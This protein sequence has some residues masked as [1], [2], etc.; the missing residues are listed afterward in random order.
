MRLLVLNGSPRPRGN[1]ARLI[2]AVLERVDGGGEVV[3]VH[4]ARIAPC[5]GCGRCD[6]GSDCVFPDDMPA[7]RE[8][9]AAAPGILVASPIYFSSLT[10]PLI[11]LFSRLQPDWRAWIR[12]GKPAPSPSRR[13]GVALAAGS[14]HP[15]MFEPARAVAGAV[16]RTLGFTFAGMATASGTDA[17]RAA[18]NAGALA[19]ARELADRLAGAPLS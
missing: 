17:V 6:D 12:A 1:T 13:G 11:A 19:S 16:F 14:S 4:R 7:V 5:I 15:R 10:A 2:G 3:D 8:K 18:D 9:I